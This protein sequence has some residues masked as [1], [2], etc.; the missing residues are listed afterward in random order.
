[1]VVEYHVKGYEPFVK[2]MA[3]FKSNGQPIIVLFS[4]AKLDTG[5]SWCDDCVR[6][7]YSIIYF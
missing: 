3:D 4:G 5:E 6:G 2:F 1:M 7:L